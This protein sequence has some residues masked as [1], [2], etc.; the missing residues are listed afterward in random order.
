MIPLCLSS[1]SVL[2][3][4]QS[5]RVSAVTNITFLHDGKKSPKRRT[6]RIDYVDG[7]LKKFPYFLV[8]VGVTSLEN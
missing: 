8:A 7:H 4:G 5:F 3:F 1:A 2:K 6:F